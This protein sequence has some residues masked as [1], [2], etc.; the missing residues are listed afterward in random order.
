MIIS[1]CSLYKALHAISPMSRLFMKSERGVT[2]R[3]YRS[4]SF[5]HSPRI[6]NPIS[7]PCNLPPPIL[8]P[9]HPRALALQ[10]LAYSIC[11]AF[12]TR[13]LRPRALARTSPQ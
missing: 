11:K 8:H 1:M 5:P 13:A 9:K 6:T 12:Q 3:H 4:Q 2:E 7:L 10:A